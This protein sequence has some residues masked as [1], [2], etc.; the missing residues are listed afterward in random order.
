MGRQLRTLDALHDGNISSVGRKNGLPGEHPSSLFE[1]HARRCMILLSDRELE[2]YFVYE[3]AASS[4]SGASQT[5]LPLF[6]SPGI[7]RLK[8]PGR[9]R[10]S[11]H[12][13]ALRDLPTQLSR[14][15]R[16]RSAK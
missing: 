7:H 11:R 14:V 5:L 8:R 6:G 9:W 13:T 3:R 2:P 16:L 15:P 1:D 4:R 12:Q 10:E